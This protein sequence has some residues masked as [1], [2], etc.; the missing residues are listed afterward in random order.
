MK[1]IKSVPNIRVEVYKDKS[2]K[3][4]WRLI[5]K[6]NIMADSSQGYV[7]KQGCLI[8]LERVRAIL[9]EAPKIEVV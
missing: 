6:A 9:H 3:W 5:S 4:R 2:D 7:T 1:I 8:A